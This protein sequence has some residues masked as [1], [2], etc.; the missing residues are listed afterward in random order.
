MSDSTALTF[1]KAG[2]PAPANLAAA[3]R[4][5]QNEVGPGGMTILKM[6]K[7]GHW[8]RLPVR[9]R[10]KSRRAAHGRLTRS[11]SSTASLRGV[12]E[13]SSE[14]GWPLSASRFPT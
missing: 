7:T 9:T 3:L 10:L 13:K 5:V 8:L 1:G 4:N 11:A 6:D 14:R 12:M 2:L